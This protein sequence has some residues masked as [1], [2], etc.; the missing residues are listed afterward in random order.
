VISIE[1]VLT[2]GW[3]MVGKA[4]VVYRWEVGARTFEVPLAWLTAA[5]PGVRYR[6]YLDARSQRLLSLEPVPEPTARRSA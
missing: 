1:G 6:V 5:P 2:I 3:R 4:N